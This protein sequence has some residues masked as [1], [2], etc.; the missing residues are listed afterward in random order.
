MTH[1]FFFHLRSL[2]HSFFL[3]LISRSDA[4]L[5]KRGRRLVKVID[6]AV[7]GG[8]VAAEPLLVVWVFDGGSSDSGL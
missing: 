5:D 6:S 7:K 3:P 4:D 2:C 8:S 1:L